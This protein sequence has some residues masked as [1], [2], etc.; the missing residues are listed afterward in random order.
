MFLR[1]LIVI[2]LLFGALSAAAEEGLPVGFAEVREDALT[3]DSSFAGT[4]EA[5]DSANIGFRQGGRI[6]E[7]MVKEGDRVA[8][9]DAL[10]KVDPLQQNQALR[11]A[12][13]RLD[14]AKAAT[15]QAR[16]ARDR[17]SAM[18]KAGVGTRAG[19]DQNEQALSAAEGNLAQARTEL[20]QAKRAVDD[21]ILLAPTDAIVTGRNV[22]VGQIVGAAQSVFSLASANGLEA[23]FQTPDLPMLDAAIGVPV[24]LQGIDFQIPP[25]TATVNEVSP[26]VDP[27]TGS[28]TL[29]ARIDDAPADLALL[30]AAVRGTVHFPVGTGIAIP[31]TALTASGDSTAVWL[32]G[33]D[34][35]VSV[36]PITIARFTTDGVVIASGLQPGDRVVTAGSQLVYPGRK[37]RP[38]GEAK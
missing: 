34:L 12:E 24:T 29:R 37:V 10:A 25:M 18:L 9:G 7:V 4:I 26:L 28:V 27:H 38:I 3:F 1:M 21:T 13:A 36:A 20:D 30:G 17:A 23:V 6:I 31:W 14:S 33:D 8:R 16:Q 15:D 19:L 2:F 32:I 35:T 22:E 5:R 11:V